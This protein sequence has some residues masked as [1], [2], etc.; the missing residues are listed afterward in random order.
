MTTEKRSFG[1]RESE[2]PPDTVGAVY[3]A[4]ACVCYGYEAILERW[5]SRMLAVII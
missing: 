5:V 2:K 4:L 1:H 3:G